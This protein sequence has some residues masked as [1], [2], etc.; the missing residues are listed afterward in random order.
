MPALRS[1]AVVIPVKD[2]AELLDR[3]LTALTA[4][5]V[6][7]YEIIVVDNGSTDDSA[8]VARR[9]GAR[10]VDQPTGAIPAAAD[11]DCI[12]PAT[13]IETIARSM[14]ESS[15]IT[16]G[17]DFID[18]PRWLRT[19]LAVLYLGAYYASLW[20]ALGHVP[21]FGSNFAVTR[22]G[23]LAVAAEVHRDDDMVH[24]DLDLSFHLGPQ[25]RIRFVRSMAMGV[26]MRPF[27]DPAAFATRLRRGFHSVVIHW[28][29]DLPWLRWMR[30]GRTP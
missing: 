22:E 23:W 24:D 27:A 15:G 17:A 11:A 16:G 7:A 26:S 21:L 20:P 28:P 29:H 30:R 10:I 9:H 4:Q 12:P 8:V 13:W 19:P 5:T 1:V 2:D 18:G 6:A 25:R 3:C 14:G